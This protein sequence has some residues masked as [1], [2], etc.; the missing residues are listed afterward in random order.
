MDNIRDHLVHLASAISERREQ[1]DTEEKAN[2]ATIPAVLTVTSP[3]EPSNGSKSVENQPDLNAD[4]AANGKLSGKTNVKHRM[5]SKRR[6]GAIFTE[7]GVKSRRSKSND[8]QVE[9]ELTIKKVKSVR[10]VPKVAKS[11]RAGGAVS[12]GSTKKGRQSAQIKSSVSANKSLIDALTDSVDQQADE[13]IATATARNHHLRP[14]ETRLPPVPGL[15]YDLARVLFNPGVY[16][17]QDPRSRVYN[18]DPYLEEIM[19][20]A[21]FNFDALKGFITSSEDTTLR[22]IAASVDTKYS[23]S[24]SSMTGILTHFHYLLSQWRPLNF[25]AQSQG[26]PIISKK[27]TVIE[28]APAAIFLK[29]KDGKYAIDADKQFSSGN[30]LMMLGKSMEKLFTLET[31]D[32]E[33]YRLS[34]S[35]HTL[36]KEE[37]TPESYHY[38]TAGKFV[39]RSQLDA[40]DARLPGT[41]M[42]DLKTRA[43]V[44]VRMHA[45]NHTEGRDYE[46]RTRH[47]E[48]ESFEREY[49]D[50]IRSAF[51][52]YSLQVR[53]GRMDGV[54]VA[55]HNTQRIFGFQY[56]SL[57]E[58]DLAIHGQ[59]NIE[60][61][62][63][64]FGLSLE[65][66]ENV[67]DKAT[68]K[69][70]NTA[71]LR[72]LED[73]Y[74]PC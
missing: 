14:I 25:S 39:M 67:L 26:F 66:L 18:F 8:M 55:F 6:K 61:G 24:S 20:A 40:H 7:H 11:K 12:K 65:L 30:I 33:K 45:K 31:A 57:P 13:A 37:A 17:L 54:F 71:S 73:I 2:G 28:R 10:N 70:P 15:A 47:G 62:H 72:A 52:K 27:P 68:A 49:Y 19:P 38:T 9:A 34:N 50:M 48:W 36:Y 21:E 3:S 63:R 59:S 46:I 5:P 53:I 23:G 44:S 58:M 22:S 74:K 29:W 64:E 1:E 56:I 69:Y 16:H 35:E 43:V 4:V 41:G 32:F 60:L 42:F 51:L